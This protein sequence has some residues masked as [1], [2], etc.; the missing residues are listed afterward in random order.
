MHRG[1]R[2]AVQTQISTAR[3]PLLRWYAMS[4]RFILIRHGQTE[5]NRVERFRGRADLPLNQTGLDQAA[6]TARRVAES[7]Q[8]AAL[9]T[10]PLLRARQ[11]AEAISRL[12]PLPIQVHTGL[13]DIHFGLLQGLTVEE[14][15]T[16]WPEVVESW[17]T[18]PQLTRFPDGEALV[19]LQQRSMSMLN[20]L[21]GRHP[22][23]TVVLVSHTVVNRVILLSI[24]GLGLDRFWRLGQDTCAINVFDAEEGDFTLITLNDTCHLR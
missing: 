9:Y 10:S 16:R 13:C 3:L 23:Q 6:A 18:T 4:T 14:A 24:L 20:E 21:V 7:W 1:G 2:W 5:W 12:V 11:T 17:F 15:R 19:D 22:G 8:P